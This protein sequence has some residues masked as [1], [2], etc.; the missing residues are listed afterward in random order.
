MGHPPGVL[1]LGHVE[2]STQ[3]S[4]CTHQLL[5]TNSNNDDNNDDD[6]GTD[7]ISDNDSDDNV[8]NNSDNNSNYNLYTIVGL[9]IIAYENNSLTCRI[10]QLHSIIRE[11]CP[12]P[13]QPMQ[14]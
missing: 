5:L 3:S 12:P 1:H 6:K 8:P 2:R 10:L 11:K 13:P 14:V 4:V 9:Q 7:G